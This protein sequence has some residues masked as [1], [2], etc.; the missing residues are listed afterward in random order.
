MTPLNWPSELDKPERN[1]WNA[2]WNDPRQKRRGETGGPRYRRRYSAVAKPVSLSLVCTR[3]QKGVFDRF[4]EQD[5]NFGSRVF[6]MPDPTTD[7]WAMLDE[8]GT[9]VLD[10]NGVPILM[11]AQWLCLFGAELPKETVVEQVK[12]RLTFTVAVLP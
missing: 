6:R 12:F 4:F 8:N 7:G 3:L 5:T 10:E 2:G 1:S 11:S 9:A